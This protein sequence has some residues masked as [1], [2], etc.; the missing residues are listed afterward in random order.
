MYNFCYSI[1]LPERVIQ[2]LWNWDVGLTHKTLGLLNTPLREQ[3]T[4]NVSRIAWID[5]KEFIKEEWEHKLGLT[6][7]QLK[8]S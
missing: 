7:A 6:C 3:Q 2:G 8:R 1:I 5:E 4:Q